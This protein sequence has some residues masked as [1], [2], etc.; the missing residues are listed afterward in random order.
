MAPCLPEP[1]S[2]IMRGLSK[3][4]G[5]GSLGVGDLPISSPGLAGVCRFGHVLG[6][7]HRGP[8]GVKK[9]WA[10]AESGLV[11]GLALVT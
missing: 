7:G 1:L 8:C 3:W 9:A 2:L 10:H 4:L 11:W 5:W 6:Q